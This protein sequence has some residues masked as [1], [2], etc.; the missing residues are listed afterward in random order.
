[1]AEEIWMNPQNRTKDNALVIPLD[2]IRSCYGVT[3]T[4][5][6]GVSSVVLA[7]NSGRQVYLRQAGYCELSGNPGLI[8]LHTPNGSGIGVHTTLAASTT[9]IWDTQDNSGYGEIISGI[10]V[11]APKFSGEVHLIVNFNPNVH[12]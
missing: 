11:E 9:T 7:I 3:A 1:M 8:Q 4:I 10:T 12:E 2:E 6:S 5:T